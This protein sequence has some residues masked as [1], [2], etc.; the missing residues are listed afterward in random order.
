ML[1]M[2][3]AMSTVI[4]RFTD[5]RLIRTPRYYGQFALSLGK[6]RAYIVFKLNPPLVWAFSVPPLFAV[7]TGFDCVYKLVFR[8]SLRD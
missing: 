5:T 2:V 8:P 1:L 7:L 6:E 3:Q 4:P